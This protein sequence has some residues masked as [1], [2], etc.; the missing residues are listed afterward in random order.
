MQDREK[1]MEPAT[2]RRR[3]VHWP[4][5]R[6]MHHQYPQSHP[7]RELFDQEIVDEEAV[8]SSS[9][10]ELPNSRS[11]SPFKAKRRNGPSAKSKQS[12]Q[13]RMYGNEADIAGRSIE[14]EDN[15]LRR[16][17]FDH[18]QDSND[19][20]SAEEMSGSSSSSDEETTTGMASILSTILPTRSRSKAR[21][22][23]EDHA[24]R[25]ERKRD[26]IKR[27]KRRRW[28]HA[29]LFRQ[30]STSSQT[31]NSFF[32]HAGHAGGSTRKMNGTGLFDWGEAGNMESELG[33]YEE[34][35]DAGVATG[36]DPND[37]QALET[38]RAED[39]STN[40]SRAAYERSPDADPLGDKDLM[41]P[42]MMGPIHDRQGARSTLQSHGIETDA[43]KAKREMKTDLNQPYIPS[44]RVNKAHA[45]SPNARLELAQ[46]W[47]AV[48]DRLKSFFTDG[49]EDQVDRTVGPHRTLA[50]LVIATQGL[51]G[52]ASPALARIA[53]ASGKEAETNR[54]LRKLSEYSN[55]REKYRDLVQEITCDAEA[56]AEEMGVKLTKK[57]KARITQ[58]A[59]NKVDI[60]KA[61]KPL[62][63][64]RRQKEVRI[65][66][67]PADR[68]QR[69][70][71]VVNLAKALINFGA[72]THSVESWLEATAEFLEIQ[73]SFI[74]LP[75]IL[76]LTLRDDT[77]RSSDVLLLRPAGSLD[78]YR[79]SLVHK[80]YRLV[81]HDHI[82]V[83]SGARA[84][85]RILKE[86]R[87]YHWFIL[88]SAGFVISMCGSIVA[89]N[90]SFVD[91]LMSGVVGLILD[92]TLIGVLGRHKV[93]SNIFELFA[94]GTIACIARG[95]GGTGYFC[96]SS[97]VSAAIIVILPGW[98]ICLGALELG[99][100]NVAAGA[101][102]VVFAIVYTLFLSFAISIGSQIMDATGVT[103]PTS[104]SD[105]STSGS[106]LSSETVTGSFT[107]NN[108]AF[109]NLFQNG[110]FTFMNG[111]SSTE[112]T[113][114]VSCY[115]NPGLTDWWYVT[116]PDWTLFITVPVFAFAL[117][118][119]FRQDWKSRDMVVSTV[120]ASLG[121]LVNYWIKPLL[122]DDSD[123]ASALQ[124][125]VVG[126]LGNMYSRVARG[127]AFPSMVVGILL[128][129]P[130]A[131]AAAGGL[132]QSS[133]DSS[134]SSSSSDSLSSTVIIA[135][136]M[137]Q[138]AIGLA[139]GLFAAAVVVYPFGKRGYIFSF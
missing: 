67:H 134:S 89:F 113:S 40:P 127:S 119:W 97:I 91:G 31:T 135:I 7:R 107:S 41:E 79:L 122:S 88:M 65:T 80:V 26:K 128:A 12:H 86:T 112:S 23:T 90:G 110:T 81:L 5:E 54:G 98:V 4:S 11:S 94:A 32:G 75:S 139:I 92:G 53:P 43:H 30:N 121:Y 72:P 29:A 56:E 68:Q 99:S 82:S 66:R 105:T 130:N 39:A 133:D 19:P 129:V 111:T 76:I 120:V 14:D 93:M 109:D 77:T 2:P 18:N 96:Y 17:Q 116:P 137:V 48:I 78:L 35:E 21:R 36:E 60:E 118:L 6:S 58:S 132:A 95:L 57:Q 83:S 25:G 123:V 37:K 117:A 44:N 1:A 73:A 61:E 27:M 85:R 24:E 114:E 115:R 52:V 28:S 74:Y 15:R 20:S 50:A 3:T 22:G 136:R 34:A 38:G 102:R 131:V 42:H 87:S 69:Q 70:D 108:T 101:I 10:G 126:I 51:A 63:G 124:A 45:T 49:D 71:F 9:E 64:R 103:Q 125:F 8:S 138:T 33:A 59:L 47:G 13:I 84:L 62:R 16:R 100:R 46:G 104:T 106:M 55:P